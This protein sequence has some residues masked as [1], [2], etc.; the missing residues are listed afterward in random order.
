MIAAPAAEAPSIPLAAPDQTTAR[1]VA[2]GL[3]RAYNGY[4]ARM[5][6]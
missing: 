3:A 2:D 4:N 6:V 5:L 1:P